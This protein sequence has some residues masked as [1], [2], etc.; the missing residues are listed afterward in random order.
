[1]NEGRIED[2]CY[3]LTSHNDQ[4]RAV[5]QDAVASYV[6]L[7][8]LDDLFGGK[9]QFS[10]DI[11]L[12]LSNSLADYGFLVSQVLITGIKTPEIVIETM[13]SINEAIRQRSTA[14]QQVEGEKVTIV[15]QAE[16][17]AESMYLQGVSAARCIRLNSDFMKDHVQVNSDFVSKTK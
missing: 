7:L 12:E 4:I 6:P 11:K 13:N 2:A 3:K 14:L 16:A 15:K 8:D 1:M 17:D 5:V 10:K 9:D